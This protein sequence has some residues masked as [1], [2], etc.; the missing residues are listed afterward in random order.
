[1]NND[2]DNILPNDNPDKLKRLAELND[3]LDNS[4]LFFGEEDDFEMDAQE[5]LKHIPEANAA[6]LVT[7]LNANLHLQ[8]KNKKKNKRKIP[9]QTN[10]YI[11]IV[12]LLII[13]IVAYIIIRKFMQ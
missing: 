5:G 12:T 9:D 2:F 8:L 1:M 4:K 13:I 7:Q 11:T 3:E 6:K 10:V